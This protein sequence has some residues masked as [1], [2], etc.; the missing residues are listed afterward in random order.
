MKAGFDKLDINKLANVTTDLNNLLTK[1]ENLGVGK[2]KVVPVDL[3][4]LS[5]VVDKQV[6]KNTN[7]TTLNTKVNSLEK[8]LPDVNTLFHIN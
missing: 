3:K 6:V 8:E 4:G 7:I 5:D 2:L 1:V